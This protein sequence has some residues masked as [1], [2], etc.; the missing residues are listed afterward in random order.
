M[1]VAIVGQGY[2]GR[3]LGL[4]ASSVGHQVLGIE[5]DAKRRKQ[6][7]AEVNYEVKGDFSSVKEFEVV[8]LATPTPLDSEGNP[9]L[10]FIESACKSLKRVL[11]NRTL[12]INE[13][14]SYP[15]TLRNFIL[16]IVGSEHMFVSA[17]ER[18][19]PANNYWT[20]HNT[21]RVLSGLS[22]EA[23]E[24]ALEFYRSFCSEV[25]LVSSPEVAEAAKLLE[26]TFRQVNIALANEFAK[27]ASALGISAYET[28]IAAGTKPY[29]FMRFMPSIGVG[30]HCIPVDPTYLS[31]L[32]KSLGA[33]TALI[34]LASS[35]N[36][37]MP[38]YIAERI[39]EMLGGSLLGKSIQVAG[40]AY[41]ANVNDVRES[42][43]LRLI[44]R[45]R[46]NGASV[47]WH[48]EI[49]K[50]WN[51]ENSTSLK[52]VDLGV[53]AVAHN[54]V[55]YSKWKNEDMPVIDVSTSTSVGWK[56]FL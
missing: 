21:P 39:S 42:P 2:V 9:D 15:G 18:I 5:I 23:N 51:Q 43:S 17:P 28:A 56:K 1:R 26:N 10:S 4:A 44:K 32:A 30:G 12:V 8:I 48:D 35:I 47:T 7:V 55:D 29:G 40:I 24:K 25:I 16:P 36:E 13:S 37:T 52:P 31:F 45:L 41:K 20:I 3:E 49:V 27:I 19:D 22:Q 6:L 54:D 14:T 38:D 11:V 33:S 46:D 50:H 53:I 34:D